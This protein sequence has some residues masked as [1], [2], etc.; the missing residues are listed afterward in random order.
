MHIHSL[1][2]AALVACAFAVLGRRRRPR[3]ASPRKLR[4]EADGHDIGPGFRYV[5]DS[6]TY[7]TSQSDACGGSGRQRLDRRPERDSAC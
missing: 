3:Q 5:H 2:R 7:E 4:V 1:R 6:V